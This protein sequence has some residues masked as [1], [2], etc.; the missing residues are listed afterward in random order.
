MTKISRIKTYQEIADENGGMVYIDRRTEEIVDKV[1]EI[2]DVVNITDDQD[3]GL[4]GK[5]HGIRIKKI[6]TAKEAK[7]MFE[8]KMFNEE[9]K[10]KILEQEEIEINTFLTEVEKRIKNA[11]EN[12][13]PICFL[14]G[15][16]FN[17]KMI[18][19]LKYCYG[20]LVRTTG[21]GRTYLAFNIKNCK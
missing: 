5:Y 11:I 7:K 17:N 9:E 1:N 3:Y 14:D 12:D 2:I 6:I 21:S 10:Q 19:I 18:C 13:R 8:A 20:Y 15:L 16:K 4:V